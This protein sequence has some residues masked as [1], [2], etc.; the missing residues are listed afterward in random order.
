MPSTEPSAVPR[1]MAGVMA[2][3]SPPRVGIRPLTFFVLSERSSAGLCQVLDDL[4]EAEHAHRDHDE[5]DAVGQFGDVEAVARHAGV[6]VG[7]D[8]AE[9]QAR[10]I[11][12]I[13][14]QQRAEASTTAPIRPSTMSEKYSA[15]PNMKATSVSG[16]AKAAAP[17]C[18]RSRRR[19]LPMPARP[20]PGRPGPCRAIW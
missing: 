19:T 18:R 2:L 12:A 11:I 7:A 14:L 8:H 17:G 10:M 4:A 13:A 16:T 3:G 6:D 20:A 5:A 1:R 15:G 9:Q